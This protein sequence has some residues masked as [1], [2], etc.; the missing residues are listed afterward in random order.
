MR[1]IKFRAWNGSKMLYNIGLH[2][3]MIFRLS[4]NG[5]CE[6]GEYDDNSGDLVVTNSAY[7][8]MQYTGRK[9]K[10][11]VEIFEG[12]IVSRMAFNYNFDEEGY[13]KEK[14]IKEVGYIEYMG[15]SF[16]VSCESFGWEGEGLW[17]WDSIE[18]IGNICQNPE[19]LNE[20]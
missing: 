6:E 19:L 4:D 7:N 12:D 14:F 2:P 11:G 10:N 18:V 15:Q 8:V 20:K 17:D 9:D 13:P 5:L 3:F 1:E 16:W